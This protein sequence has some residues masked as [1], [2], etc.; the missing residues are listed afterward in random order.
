M[1]RDILKTVKNVMTTILHDNIMDVSWT[2]KQ[3][4]RI[5]FKLYTVLIHILHTRRQKVRLYTKVLNVIH[6]V[7]QTLV[8]ISLFLKCFTHKEFLRMQNHS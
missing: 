1:I 4:C 7:S 5:S 3:R 8:T 2:L 6:E